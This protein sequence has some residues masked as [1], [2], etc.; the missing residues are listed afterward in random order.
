MATIKGTIE[1]DQ[2]DRAIQDLEGD[3]TIEA[4]RG[5]DWINMLTGGEDKV[6]GGEGIDSV[7]YFYESKL[8]INLKNGIV[9][10]ADGV[11][12][13]LTGIENASGGSGGDKITGNAGGN[14]LRG[15]DGDDTIDGGGVPMANG[16]PTYDES[17]QLDGGNGDDTL[18]LKGT[19]FANGGEGDDTITATGDV[20]ANGGAGNDRIIGKSLGHDGEFDYV[21][22]DYGGAEEGVVANFTTKK[23]A[24][25]AGGSNEKGYLIS[26]GQGGIDKASG[27]HGMNDTKFGDTLIAD[28]SV[29]N[30]YGNAFVI[31]LSAGN[32]YVRF[33]NMDDGQ[34]NYGGA[35]GA[36]LA[37]LEAGYATD[38]DEED[39]FIGYDRLIG[40]DSFRGSRFGDIVDGSEKGERQI[41]GRGGSDEIN[42]HG[43]DDKIF[44]DERN[45]TE[46]D[47]NDTINGGA[48]ND[49]LNGGDGKDSFVF[50]ADLSEKTNIDTIADFNLKDDTI[51]LDRD[52]FEEISKSGKLSSKLFADAKDEVTGKTRIIYD[53]KSGD[54]SYDADGSGKKHD[55]IQF[56][57]ID[58]HVKLAASD[59]VVI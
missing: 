58:N 29:K 17:D 6:D 27:V 38:R 10:D 40:V 55:A 7:F 32:D 56:A 48:G 23:R 33:I 46:R 11:T 19:G 18:T 20:G 1:N 15:E 13:E 3:D 57:E 30:S 45:P 28:G 37:D 31:N 41:R 26:D 53:A 5:D 44:G 51:K 14:E 52:V 36:V 8:T 39:N 42:G 49:E 43:G 9:T 12:D 21:G 47:G 4:L 54:L 24:G 50:D 16:G 35:N 22:L 2:F 59:F 34:V 25:V